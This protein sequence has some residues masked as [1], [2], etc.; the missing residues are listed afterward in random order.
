M[1]LARVEETTMSVES[2]KRS[3]TLEDDQA[4]KKQKRLSSSVEVPV[5]EPAPKAAQHVSPIIT[6][7]EL[8]KKGLRRGIALALQQVGFE[9]AAPEAMESFVAMTETYLSS[10]M[11][12]VKTFAQAAR[13]SHPLPRDFENSLK[14]FN[15][16]TTSLKPHKKP[17]IPMSVQ[18]PTW[19]TLS[20]QDPIDSD[21][22]ILGDE[23]DGS[24]DKAAKGY[25][26]TS[27]PAFPS[28][29]TYR[30]TPEDVD[31]VTVSDDWGN[32]S[33]EAPSQSITVTGSQAQ[34]M[35]QPQRPL[36][37]EEIPRGDPKKMREAAA[38]EAKAGEEALR[39]LM[40]ATKIAKQKEVWSTAQREPTRRE[41]YDLWEAAMRELIE[42]DTKAKGKEMAPAA[43]H[44]AMGRF[45][46]ADHS[47][48]V[49][50]DRRYYRREMARQGQRRVAGEGKG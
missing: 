44:G 37:P 33:S 42:D 35:V 25:I 13:R 14:R 9:G 38:K 10:L 18:T 36:A 48:I 43:M 41:R 47:M 34:A 15:L 7:D 40:R 31:N 6:P 39:R 30:Y 46:I 23:L 11:E 32:F 28:I 27:F 20:N 19:T 26:P 8:A 1:S 17:P 21:L 29:H 22:P 16:S 24:A 2:R 5:K 45:E 49:N 4:R 50:T 3:L 12:D